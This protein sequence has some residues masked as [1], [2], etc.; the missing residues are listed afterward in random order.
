[1]ASVVK[2]VQF[3]TRFGVSDKKLQKKYKS[4]GKPN[5][6]GMSMRRAIAAK[7]K[8]QRKDGSFVKHTPA[9]PDIR[10][11]GYYK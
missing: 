9:G 7:V 11:S 2:R 5:K 3:A 10:R 8:S 1:M 4:S 6:Q